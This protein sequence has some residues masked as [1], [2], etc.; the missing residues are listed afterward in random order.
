MD[1]LSL[2]LR[3]TMQ[4]ESLERRCNVGTIAPPLEILS[5]SDVGPRWE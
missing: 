3:D 1:P 4:P 2:D 5:K